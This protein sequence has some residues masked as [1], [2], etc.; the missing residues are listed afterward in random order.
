MFRLVVT[1][2]KEPLCI[3]TTKKKKTTTQKQRMC[4]HAFIFLTA[5][6]GS[7]EGC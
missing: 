6:S 1:N 4:V 2:I 3:I 5:I 7:G